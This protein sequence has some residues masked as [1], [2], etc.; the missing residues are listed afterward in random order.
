[1]LS[2]VT[3]VGKFGCEAS[4]YTELVKLRSTFVRPICST[5]IELKRRAL[6]RERG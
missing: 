3:I 2:M 1:M 4:V 6:K 5:Q